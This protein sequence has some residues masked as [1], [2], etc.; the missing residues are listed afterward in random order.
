MVAS[1]ANRPEN[2]G[3]F[4]SFHNSYDIP[5]H[6]MLPSQNKQTPLARKE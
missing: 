5:M 3:H 1:T 4:T 6:H 2:E